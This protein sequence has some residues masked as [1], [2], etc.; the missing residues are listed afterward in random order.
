MKLFCRGVV[1]T[2]ILAMAFVDGPTQ[3]AFFDLDARWP[4][5]ANGWTEIKVCIIDGSEAGTG[6]LAQAITFL[7]R[8]LAASWESGTSLRFQGFE[9]CANV[10]TG[11]QANYAGLYLLSDNTQVPETYLGPRA[12]LGRLSTTRYSIRLNTWGRS[13]KP[14]SPGEAKCIN[15]YGVHELG[16]LIGFNEEF[17]RDDRPP[18]CTG[19][20][21]KIDHHIPVNGPLNFRP[22]SGTVAIGDYDRTSIMQYDDK[23]SD[24]DPDTVRFGSTGLSATDRA[25]VQ[26]LYP[27]PPSSPHD[28]GV[29]AGMN[30]CG[31]A[32]SVTVYMDAEDDDPATKRTGWTG[33]SKNDR[34]VWLEFCRVDG[35]LFQQSTASYAVLRLGAVCPTG[36]QQ[37]SV[38]QDNEDDKNENYFSGLISPSTQDRNTRLEL[39]VF[40][41]SAMST[42][43]F[44]DLG[45]TSYGVMAISGLRGSQ[46]S[47]SMFVDDEDDNN[48]DAIS[49]RALL[50]NAILQD[51]NTT[52]YYTRVK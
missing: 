3:A 30:G 12:A 18:T 25:A 51:R 49:D 6:S 17:D 21:T 36:S 23:C 24:F 47:G 16:H 10:P 38:Y 43:D 9:P 2:T 5:N 11:Q 40:P 45:G 37:A 4:P 33:A 26:I 42:F 34:N 20:G 39:C 52:F 15:E 7:R 28:I 41:G 50:S 19:A 8:A 27:P 31:A 13:M 29:F 46:D 35:T 32:P 14:C 1:A 22:L 44:P 48:E